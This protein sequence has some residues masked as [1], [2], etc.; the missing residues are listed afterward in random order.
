LE[1]AVTSRF[2][3]QHIG[4]RTR[5][6]ESEHIIGIDLGT[7][8]SVVAVLENEQ[9][10]VI[11]NAEGGTRTP[12]VVSFLDNGEVL[13]GELARRQSTV[14]PERTVSSAKRLMGR[15]LADI[16]SLNLN[17]SF[18][19]TQVEGELMVKIGNSGYTPAQVSAFI[20]RKLKM[21]ACDYLGEEVSRAIIT[22]PAY[23][24]DL[25][26]Q[27]TYEAGKLA[28]LEVMRLVNEP[29]AA[30]MAYGLG[31]GESERVVVYDFGGGTFDI[32]VLDITDN[33]FE[34]LTSL[35]DTHLGG[36]DID[37]LVLAFLLE[38]FRQNNGMTDF[39]PDAMALRRL[40][41]A[42]EKAKC[43][44]SL[45]R[46]AVVHLPFLASGAAGPMHLETVVT[47][48]QLEEMVYPLAERTVQ[49][50]K[51]GLEDCGLS[52]E[53]I[54]KVILVGG[55][56]RIPL[57]QEM[58][59][60][61]FGQ[62]PF[63]GINPDEIV[64]MGA[65]T[66]GGVLGGKLKEVLLLDVTP[67]SLG[68]EVTDNRVSRVI[69]K[70]STI[71]IKAAKLFTTTEDNQEMVTVH[72]LQGEMDK[73]VDCRSLG[74]FTL[75][76][77]QGTKAGTPRIQVVFHIN[78][79]GMVE[80]MAEDMNTRQQK[81][82]TLTISG[83]EQAVPR[84]REF[85]GARKR[86]RRV[87]ATQPGEII[88]TPVATPSPSDTRGVK[89]SLG[90]A[91]TA[92]KF[93][94]L[95]GSHAPALSPTPLSTPPSAAT[96][97]ADADEAPSGAAAPEDLSAT[98]LQ[99]LQHLR[100]GDTGAQVLSTYSKASD[101]LRRIAI[102]PPCDPELVEAVLRILL[103]LKE[104][105]NARNILLA[106]AANGLVETSRLASIFDVFLARYPD[107][108]EVI[109][110]RASLLASLGLIDV[111][112]A[113][114]EK[115]CTEDRGTEAHIEKLAQLYGRKLAQQTDPSIQFKLV[116]LLVR[117]NRVDDAITILQQLTLLDSY[118]SRALQILGLCYWQKGMHYLAWQK[119]QNLSLTDEVK[120]ILYRLAAD[121]ED[122]E[123]LLNA[124]SVWQHL[125]DG[126]PTYRDVLQ[127]VH[128]ADELMKAQQENFKAPSDHT[129]SPV[130]TLKNSR[131]VVLEE[132]NRGSMGIVYRAKDK[133]LEEIVA[134]KVL[135]DY[136]TS[137]PQAVE[138]F[139]RE[140]RAA[141]RL[142]HPNIVRIH[143][144]FEFG[145]KKLLSMEYIEG[146]DLKKI[147]AERKR[148]PAAEVATILNGIADALAYAHSMGIVHRDI[149]PA[150]IMITT[151]NSVKVTDFGIAKFIVTGPELTRSGSQI[152]GTPLYMSP[153]QIR[154]ERVDARSDIY[155]LGAMAY[156]M[157]SGKPPFY[158][159][160]IEYHHLHSTPAPLPNDVPG[161]FA[162]MI[163]K[164]LEKDRE[165]RFPNVE[166]IR[167]SIA[168]L[169]RPEEAT[170]DN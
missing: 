40:R 25:Q 104:Q 94:P 119:F 154:G 103:E 23:F 90:D 35:G 92:A 42:A 153:E 162:A 56:A 169:P 125:V 34:V 84:K 121:M 71:P 126:D 163:M 17:F 88:A 118:R 79:D 115:I 69:E 105:V 20:L 44:L 168:A 80:V 16:E 132:I 68:V 124:K 140:A 77:I 91:G 55:T 41:D 147:L 97:P 150:N 31:K 161:D 99:A 111:A 26:R 30:A 137:D 11:A 106:C 110:G 138:R 101:E 29:T 14:N 51:A 78:A 70:N 62:Q 164:C 19:L 64:A 75:T 59:E 76:G 116:K 60:D 74:K 151:A 170:K 142:A 165:Q 21:A 18:N 65:A 36:D 10:R 81:S 127:R 15:T 123:Q 112:I 27:A 39:E 130:A 67:H 93:H 22:V 136:M 38:R 160:N 53:E 159:G 117:R 5:M 167:K 33:T 54:D 149:K 158:E 145:A 146:R 98:A 83:E 95:I 100:N 7:T 120:D 57:V 50:C 109:A 48:E 86:R 45:A 85:K 3:R 157:V 114:L 13:V 8:N 37:D 1:V 63:K 47:R 134:L 128:K 113:D 72:V 148:L 135:N 102:R 46:Q 12:S 155:S 61:F 152:L 43:E 143:D 49:F 87:P 4:L 166:D 52:I 24:D 133:V 108:E 131:F 107:D 96:P 32:T 139:K 122:T 129:T 2:L 141:K 6:A 9:P 28:G 89:L 144:M 58:V 156:E 82:L 73:A 66:Q